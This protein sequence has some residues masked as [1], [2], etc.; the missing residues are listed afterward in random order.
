MATSISA[1]ITTASSSPVMIASSSP[2]Q[3]AHS[4]SPTS[5]SLVSATQIL[6]ATEQKQRNSMSPTAPVTTNGSKNHFA[7]GISS[8]SSGLA[9]AQNQISINLSDG[10]SPALLGASNAAAAIPINLN[11]KTDYTHHATASNRLQ[12]ITTGKNGV[13]QHMLEVNDQNG[14]SIVSVNGKN[15]KDQMKMDTLSPKIDAEPPTKL[16]KLINGN[17]IALM[18]KDNKLI[19]SNQLTLSQMVVSQIPLI[20]S[21]QG[22]R[23]IGQTPNGIALELPN[24][25][26]TESSFL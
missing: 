18:D 4:S 13:R 6:K 5:I 11:M 19:P 10:I 9:V 1:V 17:T 12:I 3:R 20:A 23:V 14:T 24:G 2:L 15:A 16:I 26:M 25:K 22:V 8:G 7:N 21:S